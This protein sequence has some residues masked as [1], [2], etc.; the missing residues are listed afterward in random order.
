MLGYSNHGAWREKCCV[1]DLCFLLNMELIQGSHG[2]LSS[3]SV[4][5]LSLFPCLC[6]LSNQCLPL[7]LFGLLL[8]CCKLSFLCFVPVFACLPF[9]VCSLSLS[10]F[11]CLLSCPCLP[12]FVSF[13]VLVSL[14]LPPFLSLSPILCLLSC[15]CLPFFVSFP[16]LVSLSLPPFLSLSVSRAVIN[17]EG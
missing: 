12:F 9:F 1:A 14:S 15:P 10:P 4:F 16:V 5:A 17:E 7:F 2:Y 8:N 3:I 11:L 6:L 13:P